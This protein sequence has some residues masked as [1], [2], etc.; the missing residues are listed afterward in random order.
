MPEPV[1]N[2]PEVRAGRGA[3]PKGPEVTR[4]DGVDGGAVARNNGVDGGYVVGPPVPG[5]AG[6]RIGVSGTE[7]TGARAGASGPGRCAASNRWAASAAG[8]PART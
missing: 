1:G 2:G 5:V 3:P 8:T 6:P 7:I 4:N